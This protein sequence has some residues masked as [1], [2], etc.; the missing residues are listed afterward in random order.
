MASIPPHSGWLS[1]LC[2]ALLRMLISA[3]PVARGGTEE[4]V[5]KGGVDSPF[6]PYTNVPLQY[7]LAIPPIKQVSLLLYPL[8]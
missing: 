5:C 8:L 7:D 2:R 3:V 1:H 4:V 6:H